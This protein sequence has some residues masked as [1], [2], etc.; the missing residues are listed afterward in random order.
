LT[1][2]LDN[3][4][5]SDNKQLANAVD[6]Y[7][8]EHFSS[9]AIRDYERHKSV[10]PYNRNYLEERPPFPLLDIYY[11][12]VWM[13]SIRLEE[14]TKLLVFNIVSQL[15]EMITNSKIE[16]QDKLEDFLELGTD[17]SLRG[18]LKDKRFIEKVRSVKKEFDTGYKQFLYYH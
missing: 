10:Q 5:E 4:K 2:K 18:I 6:E 17:Y 14:K 13:L 16:S 11:D 15:G 12:I 7:D 8:N 1:A 3:N 9:Y